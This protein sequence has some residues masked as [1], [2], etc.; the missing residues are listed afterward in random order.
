MRQ[1]FDIK[2]WRKFYD[3]AHTLAQVLKDARPDYDG[4]P[5][6]F[7]LSSESQKRIEKDITSKLKS[8]SK[9]MDDCRFFPKVA[10]WSYNRRDERT[11]MSSKKFDFAHL[12]DLQDE[13]TISL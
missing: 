13:M 6:K 8:C 7:H 2:I 11:W 5:P 3:E 4:N 1:K 10:K 12:A 9:Y